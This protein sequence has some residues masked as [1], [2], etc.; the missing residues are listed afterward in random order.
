MDMQKYIYGKYNWLLILVLLL[1]PAADLYALD[2]LVT[3][4]NNDHHNYTVYMSFH[5]MTTNE[6]SP[7]ICIGETSDNKYRLI[8]IDPDE[9][10]TYCVKVI[11]EYSVQRKCFV[12][13]NGRI[14]P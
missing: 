12:V 4:H 7:D 5:S 8:N 1:T 14:Y 6:T 10:G 11:S 3:W 9:P 2:L 13:N